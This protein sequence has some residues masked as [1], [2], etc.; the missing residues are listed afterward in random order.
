MFMFNVRHNIC[1][2]FEIKHVCCTIENQMCLLLQIYLSGLTL[3]CFT[4]RSQKPKHLV[5]LVQMHVWLLLTIFSKIIGMDV[6]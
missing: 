4:K 2:K 1:F 6:T 3:F 5:Y